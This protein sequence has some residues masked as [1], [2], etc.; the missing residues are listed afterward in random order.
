MVDML[1][2]KQLNKTKYG[3][4]IRRFMPFAMIFVQMWMLYRDW[5]SNLCTTILQSNMLAAKIQEILRYRSEEIRVYFIRK[6]LGLTGR[7]SVNSNPCFTYVSVDEILLPR[8]MNLSTNLRCLSC[9]E[10]TPSWLK[11][12]N[13]VLYFTKLSNISEVW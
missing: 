10:M 9:N 11:Y 6:M 2:K 8:Y 3:S 12:M 1:K 5:S 7:W 13:H 4:D